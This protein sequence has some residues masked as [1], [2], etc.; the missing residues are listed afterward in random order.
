M[1]L[2]QLLL[3]G[4]LSGLISVLAHA[5]LASAIDLVRRKSPPVA[6]AQEGLRWSDALSIVIVLVV[7]EPLPVGSRRQAPFRLRTA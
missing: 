7:H 6:V 5:V 1:D 3:T 2:S 4:S